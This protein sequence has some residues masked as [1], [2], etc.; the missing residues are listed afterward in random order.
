[1]GRGRGIARHLTAGGRVGRAFRG[2]VGGALRGSVRGTFRGS[3]F[4]RYVVPVV[5]VYIAMDLVAGFGAVARA[6]S[7][8]GTPGV[9]TVEMESCGGMPPPPQCGPPW[10]GRFVGSDGRT[11]RDDV[12]FSGSVPNARS[13]EVGTEL[14]ALDTGHPLNVY[15]AGGLKEWPAYD[16]LGLAGAIGGLGFTAYGWRA[17]WRGRGREGGSTSA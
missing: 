11:R 17:W 13:V 12:A 8:A 3:V 6:W 9:F 14:P 15:P 10:Y 5:V 7:G 4:V 16:L 2:R 1:M